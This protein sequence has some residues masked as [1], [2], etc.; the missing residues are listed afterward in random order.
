[1]LSS[2]VG[3]AITAIDR[4]IAL[5]LKWYFRFAAALG[6]GA[7]K[8]L[9]GAAGRGFA[10]VTAVL[11]ALGLILE[12]ALCVELLLTG[13]ELELLIALLADDVLVFVHALNPHFDRLFIAHSRG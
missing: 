12:P 13:R 7:G 6:T 5:R 9:T 10:A 2:L 11:T 1:L 3:E 4:T 8:V